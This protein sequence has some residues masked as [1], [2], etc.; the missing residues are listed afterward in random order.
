MNQTKSFKIDQKNADLKRPKKKRK[1]SNP[2][3]KIL[4]KK[5]KSK[6]STTGK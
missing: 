5:K 4:A 6:K 3:L 1:K 2:H